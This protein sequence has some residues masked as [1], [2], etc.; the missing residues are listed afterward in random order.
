MIS[1]VTILTRGGEG[2]KNPENL[3]DVICEWPP[4]LSMILPRKRLLHKWFVVYFRMFMW[5]G[6]L[7]LVCWNLGCWNRK[8]CN[9]SYCFLANRTMYI[10]GY[11]PGDNRLYVSDKELHVISFQLLLSVLEYQT[12]VMRRDFETADKVLPTIPKEQRTRVAHFLEKQG[13]KQQ[14]LAVSNDLD[15]KFELAI[16]IGNLKVAYQLAVEI[17]S[18]QKWTQ[19]A[20]LATESGNLEMAQ[21]C[22]HKAQNFGGLLLLATTMGKN[23]RLRVAS[24]MEG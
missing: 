19:L 17:D 4:V 21:E 3:A 24:V 8:L 6:S 7:R 12:A 15:H 10:L 9:N 11:I 5:E 1:I 23:L 2:V 20:D 22:L 16:Q 14:A 18:D 13:F